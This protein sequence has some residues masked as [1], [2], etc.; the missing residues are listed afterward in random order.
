MHLNAAKLDVSQPRH[1][2]LS[3]STNETKTFAGK[4][5]LITTR[6]TT[7][8]SIEFLK[9]SLSTSDQIVLSETV[10]KVICENS[11]RFSVF[12]LSLQEYRRLIHES[13]SRH[14]ESGTRTQGRLSKLET[15]HSE[16]QPQN[17]IRK[18]C[19]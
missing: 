16:S 8:R 15:P 4:R 5:N 2:K 7:T 10:R 17:K 12:A 11:I 3:T 13:R 14:D 6:P 19:S 1:R 18:A 9:T